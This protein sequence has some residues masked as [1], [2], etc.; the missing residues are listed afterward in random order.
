MARYLQ[1][2]TH[3]VTH[4]IYLRYVGTIQTL[5]GKR[6]VRRDSGKSVAQ[7]AVFKFQTR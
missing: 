5:V 2:A 3:Q 6:T 7:V 1:T 4:P